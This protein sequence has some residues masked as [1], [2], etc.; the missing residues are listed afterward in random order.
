MKKVLLPVFVVILLFQSCSWNNMAKGGAIGAGVGGVVGG[1]IGNQMGNTAA[2]AI[3]GAA[4]GG[5]AGASIGHYM[6]RQAAEMRKD[7]K[8]AKIERVGEGI[9]ITFASGILFDVNSYTLKS[10]AQS[11]I[12]DL[13][14]ILQKYKDTYILVEGHTDS[15]GG[16]SLNLKLSKNRAGSV[17]SQLKSKGVSGS[18]IN[19][20]GYGESQPVGDNGTS[21]GRQQNRRVEVAI[22]ANEKLKRAARNGTLN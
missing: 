16:E 7:L 5:T 9:K 15:T 12:S 2:G 13:A 19:T 1:V 3:I 17:A 4:I 11:N 21:M 22:F 8:N 6:D 20:H 14:T 10:D 18:R